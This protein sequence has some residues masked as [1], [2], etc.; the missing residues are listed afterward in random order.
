MPE[1][2]VHQGVPDNYT[3]PSFSVHACDTHG[4]HIN[5]DWHLVPVLAS[6]MGVSQ[7]L[8]LDQM[9]PERARLWAADLIAAAEAADLEIGRWYAAKN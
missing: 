9:D 2:P 1:I 5:F 7:K 4:A 6:M 3:G 8:E